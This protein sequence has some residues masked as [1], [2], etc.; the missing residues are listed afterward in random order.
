MN[1]LNTRT[2]GEDTKSRIF[3]AAAELFATHGFD[4]VSIRQICEAVGVQKP[5]LYY[6]FKDKETLILEMVR[7]AQDV[8]QQLKQQFLDPYDDFL[9]KIRGLLFGRKYFVEQHPHFFRFYAMIHLFSMPEKVK[10]LTLFGMLAFLNELRTILM[11]GQQQGYIAENEDL[12]ILMH[13][14]LG[15][16]NQISIRYFVFNDEQ[17]F[18]N[19]NLERIFNFWKKH[20]FSVDRS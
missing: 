1:T 20:L 4:R 18:S 9:D 19:E 7:Y 16:M 10:D 13:T 14:L 5:T 6:Y 11:E 17:A 3:K 2:N 15:T 8:M 12:E